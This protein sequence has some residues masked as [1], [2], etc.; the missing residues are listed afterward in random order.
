MVQ[1]VKSTEVLIACDL[2]FGKNWESSDMEEHKPG[3]MN[4][5]DATDSE[6]QDIPHTWPYLRQLFDDLWSNLS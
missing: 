4:K 2:A 6:K 1:E 5:S 3:S